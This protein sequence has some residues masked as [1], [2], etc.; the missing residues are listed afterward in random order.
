M[1]LSIIYYVTK[2][3]IIWYWILDNVTKYEM[4][5]YQ[6]IYNM[7]LNVKNVPNIISYDSK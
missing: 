2:Y 4:K 6:I 1:I 7:V 5:W 3:Y